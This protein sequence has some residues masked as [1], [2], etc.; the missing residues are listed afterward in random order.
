MFP[1]VSYVYVAVCFSVAVIALK[2]ALKH[3]RSSDDKQERLRLEFWGDIRH[4][5]NIS[6]PGST[7]GAFTESSVAFFGTFEALKAQW[8]VVTDARDQVDGK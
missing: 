5:R 4:R 1:K 6:D 7:R 8:T 2:S 3:A